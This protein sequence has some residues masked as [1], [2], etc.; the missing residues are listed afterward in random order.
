MRYCE[1]FSAQYSVQQSLEKKKTDC[2]ITDLRFCDRT[3][4]SFIELKNSGAWG[5]LQSHA[6]SR[7]LHKNQN[8]S[9]TSQCWS[10]LVHAINRLLQYPVTIKCLLLARSRWPMIFHKPSISPIQSS[11]V[12][13]VLPGLLS[14]TDI[15][16][17]YTHQSH[18]VP[19]G[20]ESGRKL[21]RKLE[22]M[23]THDD[24]KRREDHLDAYVHC[25]VNLHSWVTHLKLND[26]NLCPLKQ[27]LFFGGWQYIGTSKPLCQACRLYFD[28]STSGIQCRESNGNWYTSWTFPLATMID[29]SEETS[30]LYAQLTRQLM[31]KLLVLMITP[32]HRKRWDSNT[33]ST[34]VSLEQQWSIGSSDLYSFC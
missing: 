3:F 17:L 20:S 19:I 33:F 32:K 11:S 7:Q 15:E 31:A 9:V 28:T 34:G 29:Q 30:S 2:S 18:K 1:Q 21:V 22:K 8:N 25:E 5:R 16:D 26:E 4:K 12:T 10:D 14:P 27:N 24:P 6:F 23:C 13:R